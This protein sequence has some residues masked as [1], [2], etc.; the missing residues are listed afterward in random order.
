MEPRFQQTAR[1]LH[2]AVLL[3][4]APSA[5]AANFN[6]SPIRLEFTPDQ[7]ALAVTLTNN[8]DRPV[9]VQASGFV[10][11][12]KES[13]DELIPTNDLV[14]SPPLVEIGAKGTQVI[15]VGRRASVTAG[16]VEKTYRLKLLEVIPAE[17][18]KK[19][20]LHFALEISMPVFIAPRLSGDARAAA[21]LEWAATNTPAGELIVSLRNSGNR[22]TQ[23]LNLV[24]E[25]AKGKQVASHDGMFYVLAGQ[26]RQVVL[27]PKLMPSSGSALTIKTNLDAADHVARVTLVKP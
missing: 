25:D 2:L 6:V 15:R 12:Q 24:V 22:R 21:N 26:T 7:R 10:W 8:D 1:C 13:K 19:Q 20:G 23:A 17:E 16:A 11:V 3:L 27:K 14:I 4:A 9:V 18:A 5:L